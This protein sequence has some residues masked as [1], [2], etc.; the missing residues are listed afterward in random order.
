M[1]LKRKTLAWYLINDKAG[2]SRLITKYS[3]TESNRHS[4]CG[5]Q[6][7]KSC[8]STSSTTRVKNFINET[9][10]YDY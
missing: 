2:I 6:D 1:G 7:F 10:S 3:G 5:E 9:S 8:V 4:R